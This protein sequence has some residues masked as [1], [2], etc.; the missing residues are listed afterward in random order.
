M[1]SRMVTI[2]LS[3]LLATYVGLL[4]RGIGHPNGWLVDDK[5]QAQSY[6]YVALWAAGKL[7]L[8]GTP[9]KA[10]DWIE[11]REAQNRGL[12]RAGSDRYP[13]AYPPTYLGVMAP[14]AALPYIPSM[15]VFV[16][17]TA[18]LLGWVCARITGRPEGAVW[19]LAS[20]VTFWNIGVGQNGFLTAGLLGAGLLFLPA[21]PVAAGMVFGLLTWKPHLGLLVPIALAAAG[22]WRAFQAAAATA[23][24]MALACYFAF[25]SETWL[26]WLASARDFTAA[27]LGDYK[28]PFRLQSLFGVLAT[29]KVPAGAALIAHNVLALALAGVIFI[30][31]RS[32]APY[33]L[34][35]AAL[36]TAAL[37]MSPYVFIY[38]FTVLTIASAFLIRHGLDST[39]LDRIDICAIVLANMLVLAFP[40]ALFPTGFVAALVLAAAIGRRFRARRTSPAQ[41]LPIAAL[42]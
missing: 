9:A 7:T 5:N 10:Y 41:A 32:A 23:V 42:T 2:A 8:E 16:A 28:R 20:T 1:S 38:D 27:I 11:H 13:F 12:G 37:L 3:I 30:V 34:K 31:W 4:A 33:A 18:G 22:Q 29:L 40:F 19:A 26:A 6:D 21:R 24:I 14:F 36:A 17:L 39:S 25:G 35:A 15:I